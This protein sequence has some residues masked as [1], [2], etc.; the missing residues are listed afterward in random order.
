MDTLTGT[1]RFI[2]VTAIDNAINT[3]GSD[4]VK[5]ADAQQ[6]LA[7]GDVLRADSLFKSAVN[8]YKDA[9]TKAESALP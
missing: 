1:A 3:P 5:I 4:P 8:K 7:D 9:L 2:A 6:F